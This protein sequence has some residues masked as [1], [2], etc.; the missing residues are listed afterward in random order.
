[1]NKTLFTKNAIKTLTQSIAPRF[2]S[3][4]AGFTRIEYIGNRTND[5]SKTAMIELINNPQAE[6]EKNEEAVEKDAYGIKSFWEW[7]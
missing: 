2:K 5:R 6:F 1:M 7:E 3:L 4:P